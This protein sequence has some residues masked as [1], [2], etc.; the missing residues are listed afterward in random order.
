[1]SSQFPKAGQTSVIILVGLVV[2]AP[3]GLALVQGLT[4]SQKSTDSII[5]PTLPPLNTTDT[6]TPTAKPTPT[7]GNEDDDNETDGKTATSQ[8]HFV[9][10]GGGVVDGATP[11]ENCSTA[12]YVTIQEAV[13]ASEPG[14]TVVVCAGTYSEH[15][16]VTTPNLT[17]RAKGDAIIT[18]VNESAVWINAPEVTLQGFNIHVSEGAD[19]AIEVGGKDSLI[20]NNTVHSPG[21]GIFL[22]DGRTESGECRVED[23]IV[24][25]YRCDDGPPVDSDLGAATGGRV[26]NNTVSASMLRIWV[27]ADHTVVQ[28]NFVTDQS[29]SENPQEYPECRTDRPFNACESRFNNSIVS[30]GNDT[31]VRGNVIQISKKPTGLGHS[32]AGILIGKTPTRR[33]NMAINNTVVD[34]SIHTSVGIGIKTRNVTAGADIRN[35]NI[36]GAFIGIRVSDEGTIRHNKV[37]STSGGL[38]LQAPIRIMSFAWAEAQN[39]NKK[40]VLVTNNTIEGNDNCIQGGI[41]VRWQSLI[42]GNRISN[43]TRGVRF[44]VCRGGGGHLVDNKLTSIDRGGYVSGVAI[45]ITDSDYKV[46]C[47]PEL[48]NKPIEILNNQITDNDVGIKI[49]NHSGVNPS[50]VEIHGNL[51]NNNAE[52]G[53][54]NVNES[55]LVDATNNIWA[56]GGPSSGANPLA[57]PYTGRFANGSGDAISGGNG[58]TRNG[59]PITNVHF[60]PFQE[61]VSCPD[62]GSTPRDTPTKKPTPTQTTTPTTTPTPTPAPGIGNGTGGTGGNSTGGNGAKGDGIDV[63]TEG[64]NRT[65]VSTSTTD[66]VPSTPTGTPPE[67]RTISPTP[68]VEPG[69]GIIIWAVGLAIFVGFMIIRRQVIHDSEGSRD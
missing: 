34:N 46:P 41:Q 55:A 3:A 20:Q 18:N 33:H 28:S 6:P 44:G 62:T 14:G 24:R 7:G 50:M 23:R 65:A 4:S 66:I 47:P 64:D 1:M 45:W 51:I 69:F 48:R 17:I 29:T 56:C 61:L 31:I 30:S 40:E 10:N 15:V 9:N 5:T 37:L 32:K 49:V 8:T 59:I 2:L 39:Y 42:K 21:V 57:D 16:K 60:D 36:T 52:F 68:R 26:V 13:G 67:T 19:Y 38:C 58:T 22:S 27:D 11:E 53:I 12:K 35:N 43:T 54:W 63:K 25:A